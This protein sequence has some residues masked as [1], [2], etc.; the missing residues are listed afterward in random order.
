MAP[1]ANAKL[2][3]PGPSRSPASRTRV[4]KPFRCDGGAMFTRSFLAEGFLS[5]QSCMRRMEMRIGGGRNVHDKASAADD[6]RWA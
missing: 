3:L 1:D 2:P 6:P 5:I 4:R